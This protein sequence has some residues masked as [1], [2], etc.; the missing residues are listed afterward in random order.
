MEEVTTTDWGH[1]TFIRDV[2]HLN[3]GPEPKSGQP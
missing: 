2:L 3:P 1:E